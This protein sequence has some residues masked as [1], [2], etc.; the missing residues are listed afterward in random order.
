MESNSANGKLDP[1]V[2]NQFESIPYDLIL[3]NVLPFVNSV[4]L[5]GLKNKVASRQIFEQLIA[6]LRPVLDDLKTRIQT[7]E[8]FKSAAPVS[9][10]LADYDTATVEINKI[11]ENAKAPSGENNFYPVPSI[12]MNGKARKGGRRYTQK[13]GDACF[14]REFAKLKMSSDAYQA[15]RRS[16]EANPGDKT[17]LAALM[18]QEQLL[19][20]E[21]ER[22]CAKPGKVSI[23][24]GELGKVVGAVPVLPT[25]AASGAAAITYASSLLP[26][27]AG[28]MLGAVGYL[29]GSGVGIVVYPIAAGVVGTINGAVRA[30]SYIP[31][32]PTINP[33]PFPTG[34][35][36][37]TLGESVSTF[38]ES[39][40]RFLNNSG[41]QE[42]AFFFLITLFFV[43]FVTFL[44]ASIGLQKV[45]Q[46]RGFSVTPVSLTIDM[47]AQ[48]VMPALP[49][50]PALMNRNAALGSRAQ[51]FATLLAGSAP[52]ATA[53]IANRGPALAPAPAAA[54]ALANA[55][56]PPAPA[57]GPVIPH[58]NLDGGS[59]RHRTRRSKKQHRVR[60][61]RKH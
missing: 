35:D 59:R 2:R 4:T 41:G 27:A 55:A 52:T 28:K 22:E 44:M 17:L 33:I 60:T 13:G 42:I 53:R 37:K 14:D 9:A 38:V 30:L 47:G 57:A 7:H 61:H 48:T 21:A 46:I 16:Q 1:L 6:G 25:A 29:G 19:R 23:I 32:T 15:V 56:A 3:D 40:Q 5:L 31:G 26:G 49:A 39:M 36:P 18:Y 11:I 43:L 54:P 34:L 24:Y 51:Q 58:T 8:M 50:G 45:S 10:F 12:M 20:S